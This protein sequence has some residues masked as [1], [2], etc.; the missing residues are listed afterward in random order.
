[1]KA[2]FTSTIFLIITYLLSGCTSLS[3]IRTYT[4]SSQ[5]GL[6]AFRSLNYNFEYN[7]LATCRDRDV[8]AFRL[9]S[10]ICDCSDSKQVDSLNLLVYHTIH[11]YLLVLSQLAGE[12]ASTLP[13]PAL[14][15]SLQ[16]SPSVNLN[17]DQKE[18]D[19]YTA[20]ADLVAQALT[21]QH[22]KNKLKLFIR[23][24]QSPVTTLLDYLQFNLSGNLNGLIEVR[25][26]RNQSILYEHLRSKIYSPYQKR[27]ITIAYYKL[28]DD[29]TAQ[30][31]VYQYYTQLLDQIKSGHRDL[32]NNLDTWN[33]DELGSAIITYAANIDAMLT[34]INAPK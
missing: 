17:L 25:L 19:A 22:R 15:E 14:S 28:Y 8:E 4:L 27:E 7:C 2:R 9:S 32:Y 33:S 20:I 18:L 1:M 31:R 16:A 12:D 11:G 21:G 10:A 23:K 29:L 30:K 3:P 6:E 26:Q 5:K 13:I 24:G 34:K